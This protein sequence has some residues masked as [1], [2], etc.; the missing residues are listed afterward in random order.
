MGPKR[1]ERMADMKFELE[2]QTPDK[3]LFLEVEFNRPERKTGRLGL[4]GGRDGALAAISKAYELATSLGASEILLNQVAGDGVLV[5]GDLD[6]NAEKLDQVF[7]ALTE[8]I[9][10]ENGLLMTRD[11]V[12]S[13]ADFVTEQLDRKNLTLVVSFN[14]L[15]KIFKS[16]LYPKVLIMSLPMLTLAEILHKFTLSYG[17]CVATVFGGEFLV[18]EGGR[19]TATALTETKYNPLTIWSGELQ[20]RAM[21][22]MLAGNSRLASVTA[23][24]L[25]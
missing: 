16:V 20:T 25:A 3:P 10:G 5:L 24:A 17:V 6:K 2:R 13:L 1:R 7:R 8:Y 22:N 11:A 18:A 12:D 21:L 9:R 14:Q 4:V 23:A 19:V 15:Q